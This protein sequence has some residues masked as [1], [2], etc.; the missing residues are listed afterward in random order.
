MVDIYG[1]LNHSGATEN[2]SR[3]VYSV[4]PQNVFINFKKDCTTT[5]QEGFQTPKTR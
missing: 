5:V 3:G 2:F 1:V 4:V